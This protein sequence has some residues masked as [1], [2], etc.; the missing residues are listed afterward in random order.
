MLWTV[1][2]VFA[3]KTRDLTRTLLRESKETLA[4]A[5]EFIICVFNFT[6]VA[7]SNYK[8]GVPRFAI[9]EEV[10]NSDLKIYGG[11]TDR[12]I[13]EI[14]PVREGWNDMNQ[15]IVIDVPPLSAVYYKGKFKRRG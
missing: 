15:H 10:F 2:I 14:H 3:F 5:D 7:R 8:V 12:K 11:N 1:I 9:Y 13:D 6:P 4:K